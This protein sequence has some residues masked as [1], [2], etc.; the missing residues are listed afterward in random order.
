MLKNMK[1]E[2][3]KY[4]DIGRLHMFFA[5]ATNGHMEQFI[6]PSNNFNNFKDVDVVADGL[7]SA[8]GDDR[9]A[10][11]EK[12]LTSDYLQRTSAAELKENYPECQPGISP[13][14]QPSTLVRKIGNKIANNLNLNAAENTVEVREIEAWTGESIA[15]EVR[16]LFDRKKI[17]DDQRTKL[18]ALIGG[19]NVETRRERLSKLGHDA[20]YLARLIDS[21]S[22]V[23]FTKGSYMVNTLSFF[24][25]ECGN[26]DT[27]VDWLLTKHKSAGTGNDK[28]QNLAAAIE[29]R[30][31][32]EIR[33]LFNR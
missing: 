5:A 13:R 23:N 9:Q 18:L 3:V 1:Y 6:D 24:A 25:E 7:M 2:P 4:R 12:G 27:I 31:C 33:T 15:K 17:D 10:D 19:E 30:L 26:R 28:P 14:W 8:L 11:L 22:G 20:A 16:D 29:D 32:V 21:S